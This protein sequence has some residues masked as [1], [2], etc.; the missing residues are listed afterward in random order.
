M[1][2]N[3]DSQSRMLAGPKVDIF[4]GEKKKHYQLP[5]LLLCYYSKYFDRCFN[6]GFVEGTTQR[7]ELPEDPVEF[8]EV[9]VDFLMLGSVTKKVAQAARKKFNNSQ[10]QNKQG[11]D[12]TCF[13]LIKYADKYGLAEA[14][15]PVVQALARKYFRFECVRGEHVELV[16]GSLAN[17]H[18]IKTMLVD[19]Y[20]KYP[21]QR[22][23]EYYGEA[24]TQQEAEVPGFAADLLYRIRE[25]STLWKWTGSDEW[26][27]NSDSDGY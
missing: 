26:T 7:L 11:I 17:V 18:P 2:S 13:G 16:Y 15:A 4:V 8:F 20:S 22:G 12:G 6:G 27:I 1:S 21:F 10:E 19:R 23:S 9:M 24:L 25:G 3:A 14:I 5:K